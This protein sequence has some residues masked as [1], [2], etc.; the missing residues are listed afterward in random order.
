MTERSRTTPLI[1][2]SLEDTVESAQDVNAF[3]VTILNDLIELNRD[4]TKGF[5]LAAA[6]VDNDYVRRVFTDIA[7]R[8]Q[9][10]L[11]QLIE[12]VVQYGGDP[13]ETGKLK[14]LFHRAWI[15]LKGILT[16]GDEAI[17]DECLD[18][19]ANVRDGYVDALDKTE[20][21]PPAAVDV[22]RKQSDEITDDLERIERLKEAVEAVDH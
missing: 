13:E 9:D 12:K 10:Y 6:N 3:T 11:R 7:G 18:S 20:K 16:N 14:G 19:E 4:S 15:N 1:R 17:V 22:I 8:R 21:L 2:E 5:T